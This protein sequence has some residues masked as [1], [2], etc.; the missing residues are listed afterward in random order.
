MTI[1]GS[2]ISVA[3]LVLPSIF[4]SRNNTR[5][6]VVKHIKDVER[7]SNR[8]NNKITTQTIDWFQSLALSGSQTIPITV[9]GAFML[10]V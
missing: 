4:S 10:Y 9:T 1:I 7:W 8:K 2:Y 5:E 3:L 6:S